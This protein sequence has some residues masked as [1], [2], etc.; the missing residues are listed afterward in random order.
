VQS[1]AGPRENR[2]ERGIARYAVRCERV[3][4]SV[5]NFYLSREDGEKGEE[6]PRG[7]VTSKQGLNKYKGDCILR[8]Q[9]E[10]AKTGVRKL[11]HATSVGEKKM[12]PETRRTMQ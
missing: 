3:A 10:N 6:A 11:N 12:T 4:L 1:L 9:R 5:L 7:S 8:V 2:K